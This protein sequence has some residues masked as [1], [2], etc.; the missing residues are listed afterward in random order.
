MR[1]VVPLR[2]P[3]LRFMAA[4]PSGAFRAFDFPATGAAGAR[5]RSAFRTSGGV[6]GSETMTRLLRGR[7]DQPVSV[8]ARWIV[9]RE[10][11]HFRVD[12]QIML[13][14]F[15]FDLKA[16]TLLPEVSVVLHQLRDAFDDDAI[17]DWFAMP[18]AWLAGASPAEAIH[19]EAPAVLQAARVDRFA[20]EG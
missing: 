12:G 4:T 1:I 13:P 3:A 17:A 14:L 19:R 5:L 7:W 6:V 9:D 10:V 11:V 18:N 20:L 8:L 2:P 16:L 15:Q